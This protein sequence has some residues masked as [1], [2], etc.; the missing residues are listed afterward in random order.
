MDLEQK[1]RERRILE[2]DEALTFTV[3]DQLF[4][5]ILHKQNETQ[6]RIEEKYQTSGQEIRIL[7]QFN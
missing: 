5:H 3:S 6:Y 7:T 4:P 1:Q 2:D